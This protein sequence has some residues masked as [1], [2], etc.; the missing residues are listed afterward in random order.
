M[1]H[2]PAP[3]PAAVAHSPL[4]KPLEPLEPMKQPQLLTTICRDPPHHHVLPKLVPVPAHEKPHGEDADNREV[5]Q[6][7]D[8]VPRRKLPNQ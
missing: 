3:G 4:L 6:E 5:A 8:G 1:R 7:L 2:S